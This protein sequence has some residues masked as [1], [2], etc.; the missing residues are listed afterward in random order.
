MIDFQFVSPT[1]IFFGHKK[2]NEIGKILRD[3]G[4]HKVLMIYGQGSIKKTGLYDVI[5]SRLK[6]SGIE[7]LELS[8]IPANPDVSFV[9][10]GVAILKKEPV[11][12][13]LAIGGGSVIDV[14]KSIGDSYFYD[15]D[16][17]DFN[18]GKASPKACL[19]IGVVLTIAAAGSETSPSCVISDYKTGFKGGFNS[20]L[21][22]CQFAVEDP[23]LLLT[24]PP[25]Q[26][27]AGIIDIM[28]HSMER[29]FDAPSDSN[30]LCDAFALALCRNVYLAALHWLKDPKDYDS[31][32]QIMLASSLSHNDLT[33]I[34]KTKAP[35]QVHPL[36][37]AI[38]GYNPKITHGAGCG[39]IYLGWAKYIYPQ[40]TQRFARFAREVFALIEPNDEK[41]A[42]IGITEM[43]R[44]YRQLGMPVRLNELGVTLND[45]P[46]IV[47]L[48][49][50]N[51]TRVIGTYPQSLE[52]KDMEAIYRLCL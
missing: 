12:A 13:L 21:H 20:D 38:S 6:E 48:A 8:G 35:W 3:Y 26:M 19:P 42:I 51:G 14:A 16:P 9:R 32:A 17:L 39:V 43:E 10:K 11:D 36:E 37:M 7:Y 18:L 5:V 2:E 41:A 47:K 25:Y 30:Q 27:G 15:G 24:L 33:N 31:L 50:G 46:S 1:K 52:A 44:F 45:L 49:S 22:R 23:E 29:Y 34:G 4:Y 40:E 28:M